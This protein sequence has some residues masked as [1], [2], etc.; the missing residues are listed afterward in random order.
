MHP[1]LLIDP[2]TNDLLLVKGEVTLIQDSPELVR[3][4]LS[5]TL[6]T[7][8]GEWFFNTRYGVPYLE[9]T[10]NPVAILSKTSINIF[11]YEIRRAIS[12][13]EGVRA[14]TS[15]TSELNKINRKVSVSFTV[16]LEDGSSLEVSDVAL[17]LGG[18]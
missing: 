13:T 1:D 10:N 9:N 12:E 18:V 16:S 5:I 14:I 15:Y 6:N 11:D 8:R 4:R 17:S 3:Q 7:F 2:V